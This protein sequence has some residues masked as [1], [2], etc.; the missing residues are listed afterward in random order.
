MEVLRFVTRVWHSHV[1][2]PTATTKAQNFLSGHSGRVGFATWQVPDGWGQTFLVGY[3]YTV[4][5][6]AGTTLNR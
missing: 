3:A 5:D 2:S 6:P 4:S 1:A